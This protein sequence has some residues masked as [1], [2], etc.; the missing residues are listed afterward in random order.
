MRRRVA[1]VDMT[2]WPGRAWNLA[3]RL[4][5]LWPRPILQH[6]RVTA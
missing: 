2:P 4:L 1:V 5:G 3:L 6:I